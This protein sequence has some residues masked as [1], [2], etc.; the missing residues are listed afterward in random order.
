M[1]YSVI[2]PTL[3]ESA[4][5][6]YALEQLLRSIEYLSEVEIIIC[7]GGSADD[8]LKRAAQYPVTIVNSNKG[9]AT[10]MNTAAQHSIGDWLVF[11][12]A[13]TRLPD[14]WMSLIDRSSALW[15]HFEIRLSGRHW[16]LR[17]VEKLMNLRSRNTAIA[18]GDQA[19][20]FRRDFFNQLGGFPA[21]PLMEDIAVCKLARKLQ[22]PACIN[23]PAITSSRRW[24]QKGILRTIFLMWTLRLGYWLGV[25]PATLHRF[26]Y[27]QDR[28]EQ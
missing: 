4:T 26:Y 7:D 16:L 20:F 15:G 5:I 6:S 12:H 13:D 1:R 28:H 14:D 23:Q 2:I 11:L 8:T 22:S 9:R 17:V 19:L 21:I 3:N 27:P 24:E 18:T 25:K 10:Q